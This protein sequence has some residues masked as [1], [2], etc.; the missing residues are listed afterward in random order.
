M[1]ESNYSM[2]MAYTTNLTFENLFMKA[3]T[4]THP[5]SSS[6]ELVLEGT[7]ADVQLSTDEYFKAYHPVGY[8]TYVKEREEFS[9]DTVRVVIWRAKSCD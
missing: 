1:K 2:T 9:D 6:L 4:L 3:T 8:G 7:K 5:K